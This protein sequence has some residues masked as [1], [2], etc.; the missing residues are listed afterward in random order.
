MT[1]SASRRQF[2]QA[3]TAAAA[4]T[5][6]P[7]VASGQNPPAPRETLRVGLVGCGGRGTGAAEQAL[8]ADRHVRLVA[9]ADAFRDRLD[10][11]LTRLQRERTVA[12]KIDVPEARCF[13]GFD[14]Y[15]R[16]IDCGVDVVLLCTPPGF[17]PLHLQAA[18]EANKH[19]FAEKPI[20]VDAPGVRRVERASARKRGARTS[21]LFRACACAIRTITR[22]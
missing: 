6:A 8:K 21:R 17:R 7:H 20:A 16:L 13:V 10:S 3:S 9:M 5:L 19:V 18:I 2:L 1:K 4:A 14:A 15:Q 12:D 22:R 11:S